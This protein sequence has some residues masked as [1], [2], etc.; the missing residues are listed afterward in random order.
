MRNSKKIYQPKENRIISMTQLNFFGGLLDKWNDYKTKS[1]WESMDKTE[2]RLETN[3]FQWD[4]A[5][6]E[7]W[8]NYNLIQNIYWK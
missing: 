7:Y 3:S 4:L 2:Q 6:N 8:E 5:E 1:R